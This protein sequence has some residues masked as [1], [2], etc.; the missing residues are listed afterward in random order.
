MKQIFA[1][2]SSGGDFCT[3][4]VA[5]FPC[6]PGLQIDGVGEISLPLSLSQA[7][8]IKS[9]GKQAPYG[10][11]TETVVDK[12]VR[13]TIQLEPSQVTIT[14]QQ[15]NSSL[16]GLVSDSCFAMGVDKSNV[17][18]TLYKLLLYE[19]G[20]HFKPHQ[21]TEK[22]IGMFATLIVQFPSDFKGGSL[23]VRH[24]G[25][26]RNF[27]M[28]AH[29]SSCT[30]HHHFLAHFSDCEHQ[31]HEVTAGHRLVAVYSLSW[32][33]STAKPSAPDMSAPQR[34][35]DAL[36]KFLGSR[37]FGYML[38]HEYTRQTLTALGLR[39]LKLRD[40]AVAGTV[41]AAS[42]L[43]RAQGGP[44]DEL[45]LHI[46]KAARDTPDE[47]GTDGAKPH[48]D[49]DEH[50]EIYTAD[51][52]LRRLAEARLGSFKFFRDVVNYHKKAERRW[53]EG[54][55]DLCGWHYDRKE[56]YKGNEG[57]AEAS[58]YKR[59]VLIFCRQE[60]FET[61]V[62]RKPG[63][64]EEEEEEEEEGSR[65]RLC[66]TELAEFEETIRKLEADDNSEPE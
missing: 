29:D 57:S 51:G 61:G 23:S 58:T 1:D 3:G 42:T 20:G 38:T 24:C 39:G 59:Y 62:Q 10:K 56:G 60:A 63:E 2:I 30:Q 37:T 54:D 19:P 7:E 8:Q 49:T 11:G 5:K 41:L 6:L 35:A 12:D 33:E 50:E 40:R 16:E 18:T 66:R 26:E 53:G 64:E 47:Y 43:M 32:L 46:A 21:D 36:R 28:G 55:H 17:R 31:V 14:N 4:G 27:E 22:D 48:I 25:V 34:L 52:A 65:L 13:S 15:W 44:G 45:V 9:V